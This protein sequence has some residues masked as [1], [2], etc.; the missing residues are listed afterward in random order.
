MYTLQKYAPTFYGKDASEQLN[1]WNALFAANNFASLIASHES[2]LVRYIAELRKAEIFDQCTQ[3]IAELKHLKSYLTW[4][5]DYS[6]NY[7]IYTTLSFYCES[8]DEF[9]AHSNKARNVTS[10]WVVTQ[11]REWHGGDCL[12]WELSEHHNE[13]APGEIHISSLSLVSEGTDQD[14]TPAAS[15][16]A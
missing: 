7:N 14:C 6:L 9:I 4:E 10:D 5:E 11:F 2:R 16:I 3:A 13:S 8:M 12:D 1:A 15:L